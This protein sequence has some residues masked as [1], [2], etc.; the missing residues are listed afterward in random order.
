MASSPSFDIHGNVVPDGYLSFVHRTLFVRQW[1]E[2]KSVGLTLVPISLK[3]EVSEDGRMYNIRLRQGVRWENKPPGNGRELV[4]ADVKYS[5]ERAKKKSGYGSLLG[6]LESVEVVDKHTVRVRLADAFAPFLHNLAEPWNGI[7]PREVED[8]LGDFKAAES[9]IG[10]G[11]FTL[12]R[13][14]P[15]VKAVFARNPDYFQKGLPYL[16]K[17]EWLFVKDRSTQPLPGGAGGY[18]FYDARIPRSTWL[19]KKSNPT[20]PIV[21]WEA[22]STSRCGRKPPSRRA[23]AA[24][25][26]AGNRPEEVGEGVPRGPGL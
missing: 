21:H 22:G 16:D 17:V 18:P 9:L 7:L 14:E 8:K 4:A 15:G 20:Y 6:Q 3:A 1:A 10:C 19:F 11:P 25:A 24:G 26:V 2:A 12:E 23:G 13:Y 5:L